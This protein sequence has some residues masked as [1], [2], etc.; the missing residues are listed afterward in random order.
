MK[1]FNLTDI[2]TATLEQY[3]M[4]K[5]TIGVG[6][7]TIEPGASVDIEAKDEAFARSHLEHFV[8]IGAVAL[9]EPPATYAKGK[10]DVAPKAP[11]KTPEKPFEKAPEKPSERGYEKAPEKM[12]EK[13]KA[14]EKSAEVD[15]AAVSPTEPAPGQPSRRRE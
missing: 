4:L 7:Y 2:S 13:A 3:Q 1:V 14:S 5:H 10:S 8:K 9:N 6:R 12:F 11:E 15:K